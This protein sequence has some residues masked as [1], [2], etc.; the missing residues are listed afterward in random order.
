MSSW[1]PKVTT[2]RRPLIESGSYGTIPQY[3]QNISYKVLKHVEL[4]SRTLSI[5]SVR[6]L[7]LN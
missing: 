7:V 5:D 2:G 3:E 1:L 6:P 4:G